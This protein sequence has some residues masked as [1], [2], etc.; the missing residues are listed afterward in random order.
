MT[1]DEVGEL[2]GDLPPLS[3]TETPPRV[4]GQFFA[5]MG[6]LAV[7]LVVLGFIGLVVIAVVVWIS[8]GMYFGTTDVWSSPSW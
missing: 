7:T 3:A 4:V 1:E 8:T 5:S 6:L 2:F